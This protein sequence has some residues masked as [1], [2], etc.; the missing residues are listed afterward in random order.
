MNLLFL[1]SI[2]QKTSKSRILE[3]IE[4]NQDELLREWLREQETTLTVI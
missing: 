1:E 2:T 4:K 3:V